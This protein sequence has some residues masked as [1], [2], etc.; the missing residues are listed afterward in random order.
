MDTHAWRYG[1]DRRG[2]RW[3]GL[4]GLLLLGLLPAAARAQVTTYRTQSLFIYKFT[5]H[6][7]WPEAARE[8]DFVIGVYG[9]SPILQELRLMASLKKAAAGQTIVVRQIDRLEALDGVHVLYLT[10]AKSR[11]LPAVLAA[12]R[13]RPVLVLAERGGL[14]KRGA[15]INFI[16]MEDLTLKFEVNTAVLRAHYLSIS[17]ELLQFGFKVG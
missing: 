2:R 4:V 12:T 17:T 3:A 9:N 7:T 5:K 10:A 15:S 6:V 1:S 14:A 16:L 11:Q 8:G 13:N